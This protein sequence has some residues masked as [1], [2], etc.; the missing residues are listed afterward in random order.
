MVII[1]IFKDGGGDSSRSPSWIS[2]G[3]ISTTHE[4]YLVVYIT[5]Q[6]LAT[7]DAVVSIL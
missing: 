4:E 7:I 1:S 2:L 3:L 5:V 6:H